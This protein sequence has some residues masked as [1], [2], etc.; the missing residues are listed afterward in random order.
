MPLGP[1]TTPGADGW[2]R[3]AVPLTA[4]A[5]EGWDMSNVGG[6]SFTGVDD[7]A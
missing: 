4:F 7:G 2:L 3:V 5:M 1:Y 6:L